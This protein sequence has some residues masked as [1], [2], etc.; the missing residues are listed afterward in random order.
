MLMFSLD[1]ELGT[2]PARH[3]TWSAAS[4]LRR[5]RARSAP[6]LLPVTT[7]FHAR[8]L[9]SFQQP[10]FQKITKPQGLVSCTCCHFVLF[11]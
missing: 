11:K 10:T 4:Q 6:P 9:S 5:R 2:L 7:I 8:V 1:N 3:A